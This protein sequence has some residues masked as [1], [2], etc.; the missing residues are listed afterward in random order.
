[1]SQ[2]KQNPQQFAHNRPL[3]IQ[4][5]AVFL[6]LLRTIGMQTQINATDVPKDSYWMYQL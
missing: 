4:M 2:I 6:V 5:E 1:M 3:N